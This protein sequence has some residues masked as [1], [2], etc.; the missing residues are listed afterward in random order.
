MN[1][2][3][4]NILIQTAAMATTLPLCLAF[5]LAAQ[6]LPR[7]EYRPP[8]SLTENEVRCLRFFDTLDPATLQ[9]KFV[10][11]GSLA[12]LTT[13]S[14]ALQA[15]AIVWV[16]KGMYAPDYTERNSDF[17]TLFH[18]ATH[19]DQ[20]KK[21]GAIKTCILRAFPSGHNYDYNLSPGKSFG[22]YGIEQQ[23]EIVSDYADRFI[24]PY[25]PAHI[26]IFKWDHM[27]REDSLLSAVVEKEYPRASSM[28][29]R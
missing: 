17:K 29:I 19:L 5:A 24:Y 9:K 22:D 6:F 26:S 15:D 10:V 16:G 20:I 12:P 1:K 25:S 7:E 27:S 18:E 3:S 13:A 28:R 23:A 14:V 11:E 8:E 21:H 4:K 2:K